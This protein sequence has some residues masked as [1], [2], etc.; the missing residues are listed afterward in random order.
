MEVVYQEMAGSYGKEMA[1]RT[2]KKKSSRVTIAT[3]SNMQRP[4]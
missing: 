2:K 1:G 3:L 4:S